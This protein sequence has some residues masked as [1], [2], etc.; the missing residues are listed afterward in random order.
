MRYESSVLSV[1]WLPSEAVTGVPRLPFDLHL[2]HYD[3]PPPDVVDDPGPLIAANRVRFA[4]H[5]RA[6]RRRAARGGAR[7]RRRRGRAGRR[8]GRAGA[9]GGR[10]AHLDAA[11]RDPCRVAVTTADGLN[12]QEL[13]ELSLWHRREDSPAG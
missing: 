12:A 2:T 9:A 1:S 4:N 5:L 10:P 7:R 11:R 8:P 13:T 6:A 3:D